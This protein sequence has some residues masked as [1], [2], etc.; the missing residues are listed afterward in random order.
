MPRFL[1]PL[2]LCLP[3]AYAQG[4]SDDA[5]YV[6]FQ[7]GSP[8]YDDN[9]APIETL[10]RQHFGITGDL[11]SV[12]FDWNDEVFR[13][14][15]GYHFSKH[16]SL[17]GALSWLGD[18]EATASVAGVAGDGATTTS[19]HRLEMSH[20]GLDLHAVGNF[21]LIDAL[22]GQIKAGGILWWAETGLRG[23]DIG[24]NR[25]LGGDLSIGLSLRYTFSET[26]I[27]S[28]DWSSS[29]I[30]GFEVAVTT[31]GLGFRY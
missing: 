19:T 30:D 16:I 18:S 8:S 15:E 27:A 21:N 4:P 2:M 24:K 20:W 26:M 3:L 7:Y 11:A 31:I 25:E 12:S 13:V 9:T 17:E 14:A 29:E 23:S 22:S 10:L 6:L 1:L 28:L 5:N